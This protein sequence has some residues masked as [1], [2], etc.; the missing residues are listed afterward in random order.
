MIKTQEKSN[1]TN[2]RP[3]IVSEDDLKLPW[4]GSPKN[5]RCYLC[6]HRFKVGDVCRWVFTNL[7][8]GGGGN[9]LV[10]E[11]CD[12]DDVI[13]RWVKAREEMRERF[14]WAFKHQEGER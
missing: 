2:Q 8:K 9:P 10:C 4:S 13:D 3:W 1:F 11:S 5:F 12:G 6:G 14:W 7:I